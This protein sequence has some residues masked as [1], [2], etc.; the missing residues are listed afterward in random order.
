MI[1]HT[2]EQRSE[3]WFELRRGIPCTSGFQ[4]IVTPKGVPTTGERRRKYMARLI[5]ERLFG[6]SMND[7][8]ENEW[9]LRGKELEPRAAEAFARDT[10]C[11]LLDGCFITSDDGKIGCSPDRIIKPAYGDAD[12]REGLEIKCP[13]PW[14]HLDYLLNGAGNDYKPQV[15]GQIL[16]GEFDI[17]HFWAWHPQAPPCHVATT[18]DDAFI[19]KLVKELF[20]FC[21]DLDAETERARAMG[22][23]T[24]GRAPPTDLPGVFPWME[25]GGLQ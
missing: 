13:S 10:G 12:V 18:R 20:F 24:P 6:Y 3:A 5:A 1:V 25:T 14:Q 17:M 9:T 8:F 16:V 23:W 21:N 2:V 7:K 22:D 4:N 19:A 15:Q 11:E